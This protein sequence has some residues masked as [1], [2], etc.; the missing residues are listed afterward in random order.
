MLPISFFVFLFSRPILALISFLLIPL[1]LWRYVKQRFKSTQQA[2]YYIVTLEGLKS[3][4]SSSGEG[5]H[6]K[7]GLT[8]A[9][10]VVFRE[11]D[12]V[13]EYL[14]VQ[15]SRNRTQWGLRKGHIEAGEEPRRTAVREV[16]EE[17]GIGAQVV[18]WIEDVTLGSETGP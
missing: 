4:S 8:H 1:S 11:R 16:K 14:L 2:Y 3:L 13:V 5:I 6:E 17:T 9:G 12:H 10:G 7:D 15:A 18:N